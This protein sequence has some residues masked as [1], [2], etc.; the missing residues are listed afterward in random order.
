MLAMQAL[1]CA[2][3]GGETATL[4]TGILVLASASLLTAVKFRSWWPTARWTLIPEAAGA[5]SPP[6]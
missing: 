1:G 2:M 4:L 5:G 3:A 6:A